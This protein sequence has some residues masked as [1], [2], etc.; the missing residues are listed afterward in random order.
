MFLQ[1]P[2][3]PPP[4]V[5]AGKRRLADAGVQEWQSDKEGG[6]VTRLPAGC[7]AAHLWTAF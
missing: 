2:S 5:R 3:L 1:T 4:Q 7:G 6:P